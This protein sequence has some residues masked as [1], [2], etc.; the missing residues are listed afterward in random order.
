MYREHTDRQTALLDP[1]A[2]IKEMS[3]MGLSGH[4]QKP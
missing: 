4:D 1:S 2:S 3:L